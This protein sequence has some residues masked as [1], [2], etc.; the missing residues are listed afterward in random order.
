[1]RRPL[2]ALGLLLVL[3]CAL[4]GCV[5]LQRSVKLNSDG[6]GTF[7]FMLAFSD[8][9]IPFAGASFASQMNA[10]G[11]SVKANGG[12]FSA[13]DSGGYSAWTFSWPF[14]T[15]DRLN[16]L[17]RMDTAFCTIPNTNVP[18]SVTAADT[19]GVTTH[20]HFLTTTFVVTGHLSFPLQATGST[21]SDPNTAALLKEAYSSFSV[22]MPGW[23]SSQS[24]GGSVSGSTVTYTAHAGD[25]L[26]FQI[27]GSGLN[28]PALLAL[29]GGGLLGLGMLALVV[30]LY[31][32]PSRAALERAA[33]EIP[34]LPSGKTV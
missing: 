30:R 21:S 23:I 25:T 9:L 15:I 5:R 27:V 8:K 18:A 11:D 34:A 26:D 24:A 3:C 16:D 29:G 28:T 10:C 1:M 7:S 4:S 33:P 19:F 6:T 31:H 12:S 20:T 17:L 2:V 22:T 14:S 32:R 13:A